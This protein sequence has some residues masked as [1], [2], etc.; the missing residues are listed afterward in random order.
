MILRTLIL[1]ACLLATVSAEALEQYQVRIAR[2][3]ETSATV[4]WKTDVV[5]THEVRWWAVPASGS[6]K[7]TALSKAP[8]F[9]ITGLARD[10]DYWVQLV[11]V[12]GGVET[13]HEL[14]TMSTRIR[15]NYP[16]AIKF[17]PRLSNCI[18]YFSSR[19]DHMQWMCN[20]DEQVITTLTY[21]EVGGSGSGTKTTKLLGHS[22]FDIYGLKPDT[23]YELRATA[24][25]QGGVST[26]HPPLLYRTNPLPK[27]TP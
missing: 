10:T 23:M 1:A 12:V 26:V 9:S 6:K 8:R 2:A 20:A 22:H 5:A 16:T 7:T 3:G 18:S 11:S 27:V 21:R 19:P 13:K 25:N 15:V 17:A 24:T 14:V 4:E